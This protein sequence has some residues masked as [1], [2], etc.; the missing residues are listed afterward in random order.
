MK[1]HFD[2]NVIDNLLLHFLTLMYVQILY[3]DFDSNL[4][5]RLN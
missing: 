4:E 1:N 3:S 5:L 2:V